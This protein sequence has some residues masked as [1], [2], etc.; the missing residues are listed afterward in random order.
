MAAEPWPVSIEPDSLPLVFLR[1]TVIG[2]SPMASLLATPSYL[3][4]TGSEPCAIAAFTPVSSAMTK[5]AINFLTLILY[6]PDNW[7]ELFETQ[8]TLRWINES[9][10]N[11]IIYTVDGKHFANQKSLENA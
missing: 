3:P 1:F 7:L 2:K 5:R 6:S 4:D 11:S 8:P 9:S 10:S